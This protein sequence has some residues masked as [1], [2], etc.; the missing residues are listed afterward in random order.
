MILGDVYRLHGLARQGTGGGVTAPSILLVVSHFE[1][2]AYM[3]KWEYKV[4]DL[5]SKP[6]ESILNE[7][8][9]QGWQL[10]AVDGGFAY[11]QR[12]K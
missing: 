12:A 5:D 6:Q 2:E 11:L 9:A 3:Q 10:I 8:G 1:M 4:V 7:L